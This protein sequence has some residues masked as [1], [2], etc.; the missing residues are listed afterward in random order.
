MTAH[1]GSLT[2]A[3]GGCPATATTRGHPAR[4]EAA[5]A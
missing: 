2:A 4:A 5:T 3:T 1:H